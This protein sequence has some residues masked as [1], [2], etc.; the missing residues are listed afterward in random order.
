MNKNK[1]I[2]M[3]VV[4]LAVLALAGCQSATETIQP[5]VTLENFNQVVVGD[6][7]TGAGGSS[8]DSVVAWM[9]EEP[10]MKETVEMGE[11]TLLQTQWFDEVK[12][13]ERY[14]AVNFVDGKASYKGQHG[15]GE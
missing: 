1:K 12:E 13:D 14:L 7:I 11:N 5:G 2:G 4:G 10:T 6:E 8:Y 15:Y 9:G 3:L